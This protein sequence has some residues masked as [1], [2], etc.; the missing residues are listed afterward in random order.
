[1]FSVW[2]SLSEKSFLR[3]CDRWD[4]PDRA[5]DPPYFGWLCSRIPEYPSVANL[6][7]SVQSRSPGVTPLLTLE[8]IGHPLAVDQR[9]G[10]TIARWHELAHRL[11]HR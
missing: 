11:L 6:K 7:L 4:V 10:I 3:M 1:V 2:S 9:Q 8:P 5:S